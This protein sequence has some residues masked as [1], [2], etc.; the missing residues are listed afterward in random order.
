MNSNLRTTLLVLCTCFAA[1]ALA[2]LFPLTAQAT[3]VTFSYTQ[4]DSATGAGTIGA[5]TYN[6]GGGNINFGPTAM[7]AALVVNPNPGLTPAGFIGAQTT[8]GGNSNEPN[9]LVGLVWSGSVLATGTRGGNTYTMQI[10]LR[11]VTEVNQS[12]ADLNDYTWNVTYGDN[13][14]TNDTS[15]TSMRFMMLL[16]RD[17][18]ID[19]TETANTF[20]RYTQQN[21]T[22]AAGVLDSFTNTDTSSAAVKDATDAGAPAGTDAAG[23]DLAFYFGWRD[24]GALSSGAILINNMTVGGLLNTDDASL[25]LVPEPG[26]VT[27]AIGGLASLAL[28]GLRRRRRR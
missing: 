5:F 22:F 1:F 4:T 20:Q 3:P 12:P 17:T 13:A 21:H 10:P 8:A 25:V 28:V 18:V 2:A 26:S 15:S 7:P 9:S 23:R 16:S 11:F 6:D 14:P 24:Q 27:I 19:A